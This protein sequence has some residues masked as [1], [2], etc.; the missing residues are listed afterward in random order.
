MRRTGFIWGC[1]KSNAA[2]WCVSTAARQRVMWSYP[3]EHPVESTPV[4]GGD[5]VIYFGDNG[6]TVHAVSAEGQPLWTEA[7]GVPI[8]SPATFLR[9]QRL[10]FGLENGL[11][12]RFGMRLPET[13]RRLAEVFGN[14]RPIRLVLGD[15]T[16]RAEPR[17]VAR[18][19][20]RV[21]GR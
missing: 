17:K 12:R 21:T 3:T 20:T 9:D 8:R 19:L 5:G 16:R 11:A 1:I 15:E 18:P 2:R 13:H 14:A 6:G 10:V 7:L 4:M